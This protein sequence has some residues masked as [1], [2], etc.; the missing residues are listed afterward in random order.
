MPCF[1]NAFAGE[2]MMPTPYCVAIVLETDLGDRLGEL[3]ARMP[4]WIVDTPANR[5]AAQR[6]WAHNPGRPHTE[7]VTTFV[8]DAS[9]PDDLADVLSEVDLH[10]GEYSHDPPYSVV[11]VFGADLTPALRQAFAEFGLTRFIER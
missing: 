2:A 11:E 9:R 3:A 4:V 8:L 7:G 5:A 10:H 1:S 6:Y